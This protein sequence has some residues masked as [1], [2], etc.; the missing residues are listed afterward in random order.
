MKM[1]HDEKM[2]HDKDA[3]HECCNMKNKD[4]NKK[5]TA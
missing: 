2:K 3:R 1:K 5:K 4:K